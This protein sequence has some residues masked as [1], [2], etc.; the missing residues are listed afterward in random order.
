MWPQ[1]HYR[2]RQR[3]YRQAMR[4]PTF[5]HESCVY[6]QKN[7]DHECKKTFA[8]KSALKRPS[9]LPLESPVTEL[10]QM[11]VSAMLNPQP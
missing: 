1:S 11:H 3:V 5:L 7:F 9:A 6:S 8:T 10:V 2:G 4:S